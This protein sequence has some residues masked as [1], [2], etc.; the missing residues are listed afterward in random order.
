ML[1]TAYSAGMDFA[2]ALFPTVLIWGLQM[3]RREKIGVIVAMSLG[4]LAG[5]TAAIKTS[6]IPGTSRSL[7]F[8]C[9]LPRGLRILTAEQK[10]M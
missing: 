1:R 9:E 4:V 3:N 10:L 2:L 7:D 6:F 5:I 8:T